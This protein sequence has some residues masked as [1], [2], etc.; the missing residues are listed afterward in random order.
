MSK[1]VIEPGACVNA[2]H[3][4]VTELEP[5]V[6]VED[7][8]IAFDFEFNCYLVG[9]NFQERL[10]EKNR[11]HQEIRENIRVLLAKHRSKPSE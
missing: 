11:T 5:F 6:K 10:D 1:P 3:N 4:L 8:R 2:F 7:L 9:N